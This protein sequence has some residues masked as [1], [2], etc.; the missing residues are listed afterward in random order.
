[1]W[2]RGQSPCHIKHAR[3][4]HHFLHLRKRKQVKSTRAD[5]SLLKFF[6]RDMQADTNKPELVGLTITSN[7]Y[8]TCP[9][10][11]PSLTRLDTVVLGD[12]Y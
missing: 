10:S 1:M 2:E 12:F 5:L 11:R 3:A 9:C 7:T 4:A 8:G 6:G